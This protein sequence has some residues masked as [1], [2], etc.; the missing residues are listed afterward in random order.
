MLP[1]GYEDLDLVNV[2]IIYTNT[3]SYAASDDGILGFL[4]EVSLCLECRWFRRSVLTPL[5]NFASSVMRNSILL[6]GQHLY[7]IETM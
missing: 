6:S 2:R 3:E 7:E 1:T 4:V 5:N